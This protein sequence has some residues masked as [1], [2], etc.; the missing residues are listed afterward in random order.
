MRAF[1]EAG[2]RVYALSYDEADA[3]AD[4]RDAYDITYTLLSDPDSEV[5][6]QF[7]ILNTLIAGDDHP[8]FGIPFPGSYVLDGDGLITHKFFENNLAVRAGPEQLLNATGAA[9]FDSQELR[10]ADRPSNEQAEVVTQVFLD[11]E[12]LAVS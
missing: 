6:R 1:D 12:H 10:L 9:S 2:V 8:W 11:G 4:F 7:G 3:L 5:I